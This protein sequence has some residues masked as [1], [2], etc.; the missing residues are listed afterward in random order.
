MHD[1][2]AVSVYD[3]AAFCDG[4]EGVRRGPLDNDIDPRWQRAELR[5]RRELLTITISHSANAVV[6]TVRSPPASWPTPDARV[7][8]GAGSGR[9][10]EISSAETANVAPLAANAI[11]A[12]ATPSKIAPIAGR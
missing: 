11:Q 8:T 2:L 12:G 4:V 7:P 10:V 3:D 6:R 9:I 5:G 1:G